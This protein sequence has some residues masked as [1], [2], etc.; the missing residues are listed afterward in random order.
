[1]ITIIFIMAYLAK[2][3]QT[4]FD[5]LNRHDFNGSAN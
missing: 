2:A 3:L 1:M 4:P 5:E